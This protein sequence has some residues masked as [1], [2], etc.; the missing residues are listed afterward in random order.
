MVMD[1]ANLRK[2]NTNLDIYV[3]SPKEKNHGEKDFTIM[4]TITMVFL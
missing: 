3:E 1:Q 2:T 4:L